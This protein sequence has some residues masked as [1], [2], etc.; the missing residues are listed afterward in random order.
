MKTPFDDYRKICPPN[1]ALPCS[2]DIAEVISQGRILKLL[3]L[4][5]F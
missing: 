3:M 4:V 2:H 5:L 1:L